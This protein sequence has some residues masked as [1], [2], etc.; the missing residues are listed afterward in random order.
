[1]KSFL[2]FGVKRP[3]ILVTLTLSFDCQHW[4]LSSL[5]WNATVW[6]ADPCCF[7]LF[8]VCLFFGFFCLF[9]RRKKKI[10]EV[11]E[12]SHPRIV[13]RGTPFSSQNNYSTNKWWKKLFCL[14]WSLFLISVNWKPEPRIFSVSEKSKAH[15]PISTWSHP[16]LAKTGTNRKRNQ[17]VCI[18]KES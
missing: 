9:L 10:M 5:G 1:M 2:N 8:F 13:S 6:N 14:P 15:R 16:V 11:N 3:S 17:H 18:L 4:L 12:K 7:V